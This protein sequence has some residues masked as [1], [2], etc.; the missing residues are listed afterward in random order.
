MISTATLPNGTEP[1]PRITV[2]TAPQP[3]DELGLIGT[4]TAFLATG[5]KLEDV[6]PTLQGLRDLEGPAFDSALAREREP[7]V[8]LFAQAIRGAAASGQLKAMTYQDEKTN[9]ALMESSAV[10]L[11]RALLVFDPG[12]GNE[13]FGSCEGLVLPGHLITNSLLQANGLES[14]N[15]LPKGLEVMG[16]MQ[17]GHLLRIREIPSGVVVYNRAHSGDFSDLPQYATGHGKN[18]QDWG[19]SLPRTLRAISD[20]LVVEWGSA[21]KHDP[22]KVRHPMTLNLAAMKDLERI[23]MGVAMAAFNISSAQVG[24]IDLDGPCNW[25]K[26]K[27]DYLGLEVKHLLE[28]QYRHRSLEQGQVFPNLVD[29]IPRRRTEAPADPGVT[30]E[31]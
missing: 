31:P 26:L 25:E 9:F 4:I 16:T 17:I 29:S 28:R 3:E 15:G 21:I 24:R 10:G 18:L 27:P 22:D 1:E 7:V 5:A 2:P 23:P 13:A 12:L 6:L 30:A 19:I 20:D 14:L 11:L 8:A